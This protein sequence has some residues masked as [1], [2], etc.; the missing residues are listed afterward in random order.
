MFYLAIT[1]ITSSI[2]YGN[3]TRLFSGEK[4]INVKKY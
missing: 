3:C 2:T 1:I 4:K